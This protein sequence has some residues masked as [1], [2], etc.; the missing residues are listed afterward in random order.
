MCSLVF[1]TKHSKNDWGERPQNVGHKPQP[2]WHKAPG[3]FHVTGQR[4]STLILAGAL[5]GIGLLSSMR[6]SMRKPLKCVLRLLWYVRRSMPH[7]RGLNTL[8]GILAG[9][10]GGSG[11]SPERPD[12]SNEPGR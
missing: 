1:H 9:I 2:R 11:G 12:K 3:S 10:D 4:V 7:A 8:R 6:D 5:L